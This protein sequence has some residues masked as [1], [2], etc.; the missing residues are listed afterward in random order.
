[1]KNNQILN[2]VKIVLL[3][4]VLA[5]G[6]QYVSAQT[7]PSW[8]APV[9]SPPAGN[10]Y[11]PLNVSS[12]G[13]V[14][15]GGLTLGYTLSDGNTGLIVQNGTAIFGNLR[16]T[17]TGTGGAS[18]A[19]Y[20]QS[21]AA[22]T[23]GS[24]APLYIG[25]YSN[26]S[27]TAKIG[28]GASTGNALDVYG[29]VN[30]PTGSCYKINGVCLT[31]GGGT[32]GVAGSGTANYIPKWTNSTTLG[33]SMI[34]DN[35]T[36]V[37]VGTASPDAGAKLHVAGTIKINGSGQAPGAGKVFTSDAAGFG[38]WQAPQKIRFDKWV[39]ATYN[40]NVYSGMMY[41]ESGWIQVGVNAAS[42][43]N[44]KIRCARVDPTFSNPAIACPMIGGSN[45]CSITA[46][47]GDPYG[48]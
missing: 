40:I 34:V 39:E 47:S 5:A 33:N 30:L 2:T 16:L 36:S 17:R 14:K 35:G 8:Q 38:T 21:G 9:S 27:S 42:A 31:T 48:A 41:C 37:G 32:G 20:I 3:A 26:N 12:S 23:A 22:R 28:I 4:V 13:Q 7:A 1:M 24:W 29:N 15:D 18:D 46:D 11:A 44:N 6:M 25:P 43:T 19:N 45:R 10:T